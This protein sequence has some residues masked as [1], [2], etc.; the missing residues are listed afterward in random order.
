MSDIKLC[1]LNLDKII[2]D[3][4]CE[5]NQEKTKA[6]VSASTIDKGKNGIFNDPNI[7]IEAAYIAQKEYAKLPLK[8][9]KKMTD[10]IR[11]NLT[12]YVETFARE[13]VE[14]T[15]MGRYED[16]VEKNI[17]A[18]EKT[19]SIEDLRP[20]VVTGDMGMS[21]FER[22][23]YGVIGSITPSTNPTET[24]IN[25]GIG[26]IAAGNSVVFSPHPSAYNVTNKCV[27]I[28]NESIVE[29]GGPKN[30]IVSFDNPSMDKTGIL[31]KHPKINMLVATGGPGVVNAVLTSGKKA[32]GAGAG[33]PP[34]VVDE[35]ADIEK[36][37]N[38]IIAGASFD[39]NLLC[40]AE[41]EVFVV[42]DCFEY[43]MFN[44]ENHK[45]TCVLKDKDKIKELNQLIVLENGSANKDF[46]GKDASY[47]LEKIGI[48]APD[49]TRLIVVETDFDH[50]FVQIELLMPV[51]PIVRAK[52]AN[53]AIDM[54]I[55]AERGNRHTSICHS[56]NIDVLTRMGKEIQT[57]IYVK[58]APS[59]AGLG[60]GGEG[61][62]TFTIAGPTGEG[63]TS[64]ISF[65]RQRRC[66]L[67]DGFNI[68]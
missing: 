27:Q 30:L 52:D 16:K 19:P 65:T 1:D 28:M 23:A 50:D 7:A 47:I 67:V 55:K 66:T 54:A 17:L 33:N 24:V 5:M 40:T 43:F 3:V 29:A 21:L 49:T 31:L 44:M 26:M 48:M 38:D 20:G 68:I 25:N 11:E 22:S 59:Y 4:L 18:I 8:T 45:D 36:A 32:I 34:V 2:K 14:E 41:K 53:E 46:T 9:R 62:T 51:L 10:K 42:D 35:T 12:K 39:N 60:F 63:L 13:T 6:S 57:T 37:V 15:G 58:N 61:F 64:P 56:K